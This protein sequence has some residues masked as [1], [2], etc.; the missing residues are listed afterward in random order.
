MSWLSFILDGNTGLLWIAI[1]EGQFHYYRQ[2]S[3]LAD[4]RDLKSLAKACGFESR[5]DD[6]LLDAWHI[7]ICAYSYAYMPDSRGLQQ[8]NRLYHPS[9]R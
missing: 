9:Y 8:K 1:Q 3:E 6:H 4:E 7:Q 2:V 5:P